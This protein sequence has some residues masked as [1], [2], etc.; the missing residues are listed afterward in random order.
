MA[1][2]IINISNKRINYSPQYR[3]LLPGDNIEF[4]HVDHRVDKIN[5]N[6][7]IVETPV[8]TLQN[9]TITATCATEN[10]V[11]V[12]N[13][14]GQL[15]IYSGPI[16]VVSNAD[17]CFFAIKGGMIKS[18]EKHL[19][20]IVT[21]DMP[22][23]SLDYRYGSVTLTNPNSVG[24]IYY[25]TDGTTPSAINGTQYNGAFIL[26]IGCI[27]K[28]CVVYNNITSPVLTEQVNKIYGGPS[29]V[30]LLNDIQNN[31]IL[32]IRVYS[33]S[34]NLEY[35]YTL[36]NTIPNYYSSVLINHQN[37]EFQ[38]YGKIT[39]FRCA[40]FKQNCIPDFSFDHELGYEKPTS[41]AITFD[42]T[43]N[44][45][46]I[47]KIRGE[48]NSNNSSYFKV[49]YTTDGTTPTKTS[50]EYTQPFTIS[51]TTTVKAI[52]YYIYVEADYISDITEETITI[53]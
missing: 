45:V 22:V 17:F 15:K 24:T 7:A 50:A 14:N 5:A 48:I 12:Y 42:N 8:V 28:S 46:T 16:Q 27:L 11:I 21:L 44:T 18:E 32:S 39:H 35:R 10:S 40:A 41:P 33:L 26:T 23:Y 52:T 2:E 38:L 4:T 19:N 31:N 1:N 37:I 47:D 13:E 34:S 9:N 53:N 30:T 36:D 29:Y 49:Y 6:G 20:V 25:T 3:N 51:Q 43:T